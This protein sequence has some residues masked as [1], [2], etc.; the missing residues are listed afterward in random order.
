MIALK[1]EVDAAPVLNACRSYSAWLGKDFER[2]VRKKLADWAFK[3]AAELK[4][5]PK[6]TLPPFPAKGAKDSARWR[7]VQWIRNGRKE[8]GLRDED[9]PA[10]TSKAEK[11]ARSRSRRFLAAMA[12]TGARAASKAVRPGQASVKGR[13]GIVGGAGSVGSGGGFTANVSG[14][15]AFRLPYTRAYRPVRPEPVAR[16][17][18]AAFAKTTPAVIADTENYVREELARRAEGGVR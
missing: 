5:Q 17:I 1:A 7:L 6:A 15:F 18:A 12:A 9:G 14:R 8:R 2:C 16:R 4:A 10:G 13:R 11:S 3:A